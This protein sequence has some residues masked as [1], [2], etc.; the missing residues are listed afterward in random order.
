MKKSETLAIIIG[1][2][3]LSRCAS[4]TKSQ[5]N[6]VNQFSQLTESFSCYP[7]KV[8]ATLNDV[9]TR[10]QFFIAG[11]IRD[12]EKH[13]QSVLK[14]DTFRKTGAKL[15]IEAGLA[16]QVI[17]DYSQKLVCLTA[18]VYSPKLD[19]A[20][21]P[22][23]ANLDNLIGKYNTVAPQHAV[24]IGIGALFGELVS[25][26]GDLYIHDRQ[27]KGTK[28]FVTRGDTLIGSM[29]VTLEGFLSGN[30]NSLMHSIARERENVD[31]NYLEFLKRNDE[32]VRITY[33]AD[34][35]YGKNKLR[36][37]DSL[38]KKDVTVTGQLYA[39]RSTGI[40][41]DSLYI[42]LLDNLDA[43]ELLRE[44]CLEA[45]KCLRKAHHKL[46]ED[47][48]QKKTLKEVY[49]ELQDYGKSIGQ[50]NSTLKTIK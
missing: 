31:N 29:A 14:I 30:D 36:K 2:L 28:E 9:R 4:L 45:V 43:D 17:S 37:K 50:M 11:S 27:A 3:L 26:G 41:A 6:Q 49:A 40:G 22:L 13:Q 5:L 35:I 8:F 12:P 33:Q 10:E 48:Q 25:F 24:P 42:N 46:M 18:N 7:Q 15:D 47:L 39:W 34:T 21:I 16:F 1:L 32:E 20:S 23:G 19:T 38:G 44:Q